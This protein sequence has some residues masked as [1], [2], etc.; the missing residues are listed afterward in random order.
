MIPRASA[1]L[2]Q[3]ATIYDLAVH[4]SYQ[5]YGI[6]RRCLQ[7][8]VQQL[9]RRGVYD[10]GTVCP[11]DALEFFSSC[12][13]E[14]DR[15]GSTCMTLSPAHFRSTDSQQLQ[16]PPSACL[17]RK[18]QHEMG[19]YFALDESPLPVPAAAAAVAKADYQI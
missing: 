3:V 5:G 11:T 6:G 18:L 19:R 7:L 9:Y 4:P 12:S 16:L 10:I 2:L 1:C 14:V 8:L 17:Q 13:F 15:E